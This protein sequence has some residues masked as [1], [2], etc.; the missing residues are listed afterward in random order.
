M[1]HEVQARVCRS[2]VLNSTT[3]MAITT[4]IAL[5]NPTHYDIAP[6]KAFIMFW[7]YIAGVIASSYSYSQ[8]PLLLDYRYWTKKF[9]SSL[10]RAM[11]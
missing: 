5:L 3:I 10:I 8:N 6:S 4:D 1:T 2:S 9:R 11:W 7:A